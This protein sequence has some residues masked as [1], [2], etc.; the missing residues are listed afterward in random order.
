[1]ILCYEFDFPSDVLYFCWLYYFYTTVFNL[2]FSSVGNLF[3]SL[4][5]VYQV[6]DVL[7]N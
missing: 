6:F 4:I 1:M 2:E 7:S 5:H 3:I